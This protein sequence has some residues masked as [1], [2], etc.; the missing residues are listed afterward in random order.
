MHSRKENRVCLTLTHFDYDN[1][2]T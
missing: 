2:T 1:L